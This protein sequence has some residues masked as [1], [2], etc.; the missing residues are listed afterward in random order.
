MWLKVQR[1]AFLRRQQADLRAA[2]A[3]VLQ[4]PVQRQ[5]GLC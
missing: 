2:V 1:L 3:K 5:A 4:R